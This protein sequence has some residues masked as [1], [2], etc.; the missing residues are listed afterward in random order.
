MLIILI[1]LLWK[2]P[3]IIVFYA[4][5]YWFLQW[6]KPVKSYTADDTTIHR[7]LESNE[8]EREQEKSHDKQVLTIDGSSP[9]GQFI[10]IQVLTKNNRHEAFVA[11]SQG[12]NLY[13]NRFSS[14]VGNDAGVVSCGPLNLELRVP[15]QRWRVS[16]RGYLKGP[17]EQQHFVC[18]G[19]WWK[20]LSNARTFYSNMGLKPLATELRKNKLGISTN[21]KLIERF[22]TAKLLTQ[23]GELHLEVK[24]NDEAIQHRFRGVWEKIPLDLIDNSQQITFF[25]EDGNAVSHKVTSYDNHTVTLEHGLFFTS[26]HKVRSIKLKQ[27]EALDSSNLIPI[28]FDVKK[29][30][31]TFQLRKDKTLSSFS[32]TRSDGRLVD[33]AVV[34][35][36]HGLSN[37][38][39]FISNVRETLQ[40]IPEITNI[41]TFPAYFAS[42]NERN[43]FVLPFSHRACQDKSLA[44]GKGANLA[45]LQC[46]TKGFQ[47]PP[48]LVVT[49]TAFNHHIS[50]LEKLIKQLETPAESNEFYVKIGHEIEGKLRD[51]SVSESLLEEILEHLPESEYYAV[52]SSAVGEDGADLSSAGQLES[53]LDVRKDAIVEKLKLCWASNFRTEVISYRRNYGQQLNPPMAV[54]IQEMSRNGVAGVMFTADPV[55][56]DPGRLLINAL[57]GCGELIVSGAETPDEISLHRIF[58]KIEKPENCCLSNEEISKLRNVGEHLENVFG[59]PQDV[60]FVVRDRKV[61]VVQTRDVTGLDKESHF[62]LYNEFDTPM[63]LDKEALTNANVGEVLAAPMTPFECNTLIPLYDKS[64]TAMSLRQVNGRVPAHFCM[65]FAVRHRKTFMNLGEAMLQTWENL[66]KD[67]ITDYVFAG[68]KLFTE[69]MFKDAEQRYGYLSPLFPIKM[70]FDMLKMTFYT[71]YKI[72][73]RVEQIE[74]DIKAVAPNCDLDVHSMFKLF[75]KQSLLLQSAL[76]SHGML[77]MFSSFTYVIVGML[78]RGSDSGTLS[79]DNLSDIANVFSNNTRTDVISAD[80][81]SSLKKLAKA[82]REDGL[83][84]EFTKSEG[85]Q[86]LKVIEDRGKV[87]KELLAR[88]LRIHGHRGPKELFLDAVTWAEDTDLLVHTLKSMLACPEMAEKL[89]E[90]TDDIIDTLK[91]KPTGLRRTLLKYFIGQTHRGVAFRETAKNYLVSSTHETRKSLRAI[92]EK[93]HRMGYLPDP[94]LTFQMTLDELKELSVSRSAKLVSRA[95]RRKNFAHHFEGLQFPMVVYGKMEPIKTEEAAVYTEKSVTLTGTTVC[96]GIIIAR[97]RVAK[98]LD[99][100]RETKPGEILITRY[101]D[102]C[103]S[104]FFPIIKGIV[105]EIGGLLSHGAVVAREYGLPSLI[106][107]TNATNV[108][109][110]GDL[111]ELNAIKGT[112]SRVEEIEN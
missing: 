40:D 1:P 8:E 81:P 84:E 97:A 42:T 43:R 6:R 31:P 68:E 82:V 109:R 107:V 47:V 15:F 19:G 73:K 20:A 37:G 100:A 27:I 21:I 10:Y 25:L 78:I 93:L 74:K 95:I 5:I 106:A 86:A 75:E 85:E 16:F 60:E 11:V 24:I 45:R 103:W 38:L 39:A 89:I 3:W 110:T 83:E 94:K 57:K 87:S 35:V 91:C 22:R 64:I 13:Q 98:N 44:G 58:N 108:F 32:Y 65:T 111:V 80:V 79:A 28:D 102:I 56:N 48:G 52:R 88:F 96:E 2:L 62:E 51:S 101:T 9:D 104:P 18:V 46:I 76:Y 70:M 69:E 26:N 41:E 90:N 33:V 54:V 50:S 77:S 112:I 67:E 55:K 4:P 71:S 12:G 34:K 23:L 66:K 30:K 99:E 36:V 7:I 72:L 49:T 29:E 92:G 61:F 14:A 17:D 63:Y 53:Y 59:K 105:T